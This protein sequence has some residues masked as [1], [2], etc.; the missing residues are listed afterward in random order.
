MIAFIHPETG[1][2]VLVGRLQSPAWQTALEDGSMFYAGTVVL[3]WCFCYFCAWE[4]LGLARGVT[5]PSMQEH[6]TVKSAHAEK[7]LKDSNLPM[8][9]LWAASKVGSSARL[10][11]THP[12]VGFLH[13]RWRFP[14][15]QPCLGQCLGASEKELKM[16]LK[17]PPF[18]LAECQYI[19]VLS[20]VLYYC[21]NA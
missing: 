3:S 13:G 16:H 12:A 14:D 1:V 19:M 9:N 8:G 5:K 11:H 7:L 15:S 21:S 4:A 18:P 2:F 6:R 10:I 20:D 17:K